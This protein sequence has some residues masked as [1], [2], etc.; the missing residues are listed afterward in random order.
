[1]FRNIFRPVIP[2]LVYNLLRA[3]DHKLFIGVFVKVW[4][5]SKRLI[6][7]FW[8]ISIFWFGSPVI[9]SLKIVA[10][11]VASIVAEISTTRISQINVNTTKTWCPDRFPSKTYPM[12]MKKPMNK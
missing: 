9:M 3:M 6:N 12:N 10:L 5:F 1:M 4:W 2:D 11:I 7:Y 8:W